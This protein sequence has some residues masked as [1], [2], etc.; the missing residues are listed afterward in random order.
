MFLRYDTKGSSLK[1]E[2]GKPDLEPN[3]EPTMVWGV[4]W[5]S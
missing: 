5:H 3:I 1:G 4:I 2:V